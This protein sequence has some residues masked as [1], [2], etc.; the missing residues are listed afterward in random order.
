ML[1]EAKLYIY[2]NCGIVNTNFFLGVLNKK[3][4]MWG[5]KLIK[6][7]PTFCETFTIHTSTLGIVDIL[8]L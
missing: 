5:A 4:V 3:L 1:Q 6:H 7:L 2:S 8:S